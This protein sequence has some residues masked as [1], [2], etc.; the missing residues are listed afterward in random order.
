MKSY[1]LTFLLFLTLGLPVVFAQAEEANC[2]VEAWV[3]DKDPNGLNVRN[4]PNVQGKII[5]KLKT[6]DEDDYVLINVTG[7]QNGWLQ[8][9]AASR[10]SGKQIFS[11]IGWVSANMVATGV[12]GTDG[13]YDN[14]AYIYAETN[15][16]SKKIAG[17]PTG[18]SVKI[19]GWKCGW[20]KVMFRGTTGWVQYAN[21]CGNP[22]SSCS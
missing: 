21:I 7:Y 16:K 2:S 1:I 6:A 17:I 9:G 19:V 13:N 3:T 10:I 22:V 15:L 8:I 18:E 12:R 5:A 14:P 4:T 20:V 11:N